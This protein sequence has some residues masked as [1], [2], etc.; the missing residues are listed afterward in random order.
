MIP[1]NHQTSSNGNTY[2]TEYFQT[3]ANIQERVQQLDKEGFTVLRCGSNGFWSGYSIFKRN[4]D[5]TEISYVLELLFKDP[6]GSFCSLHGCS[7][8]AT[9]AYLFVN[10]IGENSVV[11]YCQSCMTAS[12]A[13]R[14]VLEKNEDFREI[15]LKEADIINVMSS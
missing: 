10:S 13:S 5:G 8:I 11:R 12:K 14:D 3:I 6:G 4:E 2:V 15:S 1:K 9:C 7:E